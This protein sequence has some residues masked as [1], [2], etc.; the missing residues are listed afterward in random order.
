MEWILSGVDFVRRNCVEG[1]SPGVFCP[2]FLP[3][4]YTMGHWSRW[5]KTLATCKNADQAATSLRGDNS[6][7]IWQVQ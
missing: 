5:S 4:S 6:T 7:V 2:G 1:L 3:C